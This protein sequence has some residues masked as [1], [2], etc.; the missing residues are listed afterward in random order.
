MSLIHGWKFQC[1]NSTCLPFINVITSP[2]IKCQIACLAQTYCRAASFHQLT[3]NCELFTDMSNEIAHMVTDMDIITMVVIAGARSSSEPTTTT[4][5]STTTSSTTKTSTTTSTTTSSTTKTSTTTAFT[6]RWNA[7]GT[8][9]A[10][11]AGGTSG[12]SASL[13]SGPYVVR[14]DS[15]NALYISD[16]SNNRI[17]KWVIGNSAGTTVAGLPNGTS[18]ASSTTL[19]Q[20]VGL[21]IDSS[22]N[23]YIADKYNHRVMYWENGASSGSM[24][25]GTGSAGSANNQFNGC[26][27][28]E[29]V[30]S[31]GTLYISDLA[32]QRIMQYLNGSSSGTVVAG[33]NGAGTGSTQLWYPFGFTLDSSTNSLIIANYDAHSVVRWVIGDTSWTLL[34]GSSTGVSGSSSTLLNSPVGVAV[35]Q[36]GNIYVADS[37]NHRIQFFLAGQSSATTISGVTGSAGISA[38]QL[39]SPYG[40]TLDSQFNLY[41]AD[42]GN[43]RVQ[44]FARY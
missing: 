2:I 20:P 17:Q 6:A 21:V 36:Y 35:D 42:T 33:G 27:T 14:L 44:R 5:S 15:T 18:G 8:T 29:R 40:V 1:T 22:N 7:T 9:V 43:N 31:S 19:N 24:I 30:S 3:S 11:N 26:N 37:S 41:V 16:I 13:L 32:N 4:T 10:G 28:V 12:V 38:T 34:A 39:N 25:A 23:M